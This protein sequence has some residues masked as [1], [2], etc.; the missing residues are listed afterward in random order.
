M[1]AGVPWYG[2]WVKISRS[3]IRDLLSTLRTSKK[4]IPLQWFCDPGMTPEENLGPERHRYKQPT[5]RTF[6]GN[7]SDNQSSSYFIFNID[8]SHTEAHSGWK[9]KPRTTFHR[10]VIISV[11][12]NKEFIR[13][14]HFTT[15]SGAIFTRL[16]RCDG[17]GSS[18]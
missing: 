5:R 18:M 17:H 8:G 14:S 13:H 10:A 1:R 4:H 6:R 2:K 16:A 11:P 7:V 12:E 15:D 9:D 3:L